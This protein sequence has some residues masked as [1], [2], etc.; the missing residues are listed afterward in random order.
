MINI[1][2]FSVYISNHGFLFQRRGVAP[3]RDID[4][5]LVPFIPNL[6]IS[7]NLY[8]LEITGAINT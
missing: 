5:N 4:N 6:L 2:L 7:N 8:R 1:S 3:L